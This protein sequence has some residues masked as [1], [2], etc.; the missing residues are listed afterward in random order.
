MEAQCKSGMKLKLVH[1]KEQ[2]LKFQ[3]NRRVSLG[4]HCF[5]ITVYLYYVTIKQFLIPKVTNIIS[6]GHI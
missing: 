3:K 2:G 5:N 1:T 6:Q 4:K